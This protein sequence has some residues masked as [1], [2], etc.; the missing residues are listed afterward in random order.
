MRFV[1]GRCATPNRTLRLRHTAVP[2]VDP[3]VATGYEADGM[4]G[5]PIY[6]DGGSLGYTGTLE[7]RSG[8]ISVVAPGGESNKLACGFNP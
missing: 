5:E 3:P 4:E 8:Y 7:V 6:M 1:R 2:P